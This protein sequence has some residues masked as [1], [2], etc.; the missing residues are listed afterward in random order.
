VC[1]SALQLVS[2]FS[3]GLL[4]FA[5]VILPIAAGAVIID[6]AMGTRVQ[7]DSAGDMRG[8]VL[9]A[10]SSVSAA[11]GALGGPLVGWMS[12]TWGPQAALQVSGVIALLATAAAAAALVRIRDAG[13]AARFDPR[14]GAEPVPVLA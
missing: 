12:Q 9:A 13:R 10:Q 7:L 1:C 6:T 14:P 8:R 2:G 5:A 3:P 11:A 4:T